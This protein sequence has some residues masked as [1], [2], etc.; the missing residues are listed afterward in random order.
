M[1]RKM[2]FYG[3]LA[4]GLALG[5]SAVWTLTAR[6]GYESAE[7]KVVEKD[8]NIEIREYPDLMLASTS[9]KVD[10]QG[11]EGSFM[12]LFGYISGA[13]QSEQKIAMTTPVFM[14]TGGDAKMSFVL[15]D[16]VAGEGAPSPKSSQ[17]SVN[18]T[19]MGRVAVY[20]YSGKW[21]SQQRD[22]AREK[23]A[24]WLR[25]EGLSPEGEIF[26]AGYDP[27]YTP[28]FL[29]RNEVLVQVKS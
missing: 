12:R 14:T 23:L 8:G 21:N 24:A 15:P 16:K 25:D 22:A 27:P 19:T 1:T 5:G 9:T 18:A 29:R 4:L 17:L 11:R 28:G 6:A 10:A 26:Y 7:Y 20:R 2:M 3:V 13:N